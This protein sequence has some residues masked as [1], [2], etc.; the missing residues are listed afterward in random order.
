MEPD[1]NMNE[2]M[3]GLYIV[4]F[5]AIPIVVILLVKDYIRNIVAC[6]QIKLSSNYQF[7]NSFQFD[8][9]KKCRI[10]NIGLQETIVQDIEKEQMLVIPNIE[11]IKMKIWRN[12][13]AKCWYQ[14]DNCQIKD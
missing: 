14:K 6:I 3:R 4:L 13:D 5:A 11:F 12:I 7:V 2:M 10:F 1:L 9:R 8:E